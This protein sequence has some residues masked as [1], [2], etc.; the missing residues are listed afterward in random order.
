[1]RIKDQEYQYTIFLQE[2]EEG[3]YI[4]DV[5]SLPGC[6]S[7]GE[8]IEEA[9]S[10]VKDAIDTYL[11]ALIQRRKKIPKE[12]GEVIVRVKGRMPRVRKTSFAHP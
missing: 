2:A 11:Q 4:A 8:T 7:Q 10:F 6:M 3:G 9:V 1:M 12:N 5:P